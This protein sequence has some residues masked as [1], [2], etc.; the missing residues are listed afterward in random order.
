[1][2]FFKKLFLLSCLLLQAQVSFGLSIRDI[3]QGVVKVD[4]MKGN[5]GRYFTAKEI[6]D[7]NKAWILKGGLPQVVAA[8]EPNRLTDPGHNRCGDNV[9]PASQC[10][11]AQQTAWNNGQGCINQTEYNYALNNAI[12]PLCAQ[13]N[14]TQFVG[15]C[16][17][18]CFEKSTQ[19]LTRVKAENRLAQVGV[20]VLNQ[21]IFDAYTMTDDSTLYAPIWEARTITATTVGTEEKPLVW[22]HLEN[23]SSIGLTEEHA[24]LTAEG[25]MLTAKE[26]QAGQHQMVTAEGEPVLIKEIQR[27]ATKDPVYN[28]LTDAGLNHKGHMVVANGVVVGDIMWQNTLAKDLQR[29]VVRM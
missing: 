2:R 5:L 12:A 28:L 4:L 1:M 17:C 13:W 22:V 27:V 9:L 19:I 8:N 24:V 21:D 26:L 14:P 18:G 25:I 16:R 11:T 15:W 23:G 6:D 29:V 3:N 20:D 10:P 7:Y